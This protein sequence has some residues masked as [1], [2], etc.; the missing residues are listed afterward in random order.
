M[1]ITP[2]KVSVKTILA[3]IGS[4]GYAVPEFQRKFV[5]PAA[6][7]TRLF[8]SI[9]SNLY[10]GSLLLLENRANLAQTMFGS[11]NVYGGPKPKK[12]FMLILDGQQ[13]LTSIFYAATAP[14]EK[15]PNV[16]IVNFHIKTSE[17]RSKTYNPLQGFQDLENVFHHFREGSPK[18]ARAMATKEFIPLS[19]LLVVPTSVPEEKK[20][21]K[22][23]AEYDDEIQF[24]LT[25]LRDA[26]LEYQFPFLK[27]PANSS[28]RY[29]IDCFTRINE[30]GT[31]LSRFDLAHARLTNKNTD[32]RQQWEE[33]VA[34]SGKRFPNLGWGVKSKLING[35]SLLQAMALLHDK[36]PRQEEIF[37]L[38]NDLSQKA[39]K[40]T[41]E[42][43]ILALERAIAEMRGRYGVITAQLVPAKGI[44]PVLGTL[45]V[46]LPPKAKAKSID[47]LDAWYWASI[48]TGKYIGGV[49]TTAAKDRAEISVWLQNI[50]KKPTWLEALTSGDLD[51]NWQRP[52]QPGYKAVM[53]ALIAAGLVDILTGD[54][55]QSTKKKLQDDH[56]FSKEHF[57]GRWGIDALPN[58]LMMLAPN[59]GTA[60]KGRARP[61]EWCVT[62]EESV[63]PAPKLDKRL[64]AAMIST[65]AWDT[66]VDDNFDS[67]QR[68]RASSLRK[69]CVEFLSKQ[70]GRPVEDLQVDPQEALAWDDD[71]DDDDDDLVD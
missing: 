6:H 19:S 21:K 61:S 17:I 59:N 56:I 33:A 9:G 40:Q 15:L 35:D 37:R 70:L 34:E 13:R 36:E 10:A 23:L 51:L 49:N 58:R 22:W 20:F 69:F 64:N 12:E 32:L 28:A 16:G 18:L 39:I 2:D 57:R 60:G 48:L 4:G 63:I 11:R 66:M 5:W 26:I 3:E 27:L 43:G 38:I 67:F 30:G 68:L 29:I 50:K 54:V 46:D 1:L 65:S 25:K 44:I 45:L 52:K 41:I 8:E 71:D 24:Q 7:I 42:R 53:T 55:L 62:L 47:R 31:P 14:S